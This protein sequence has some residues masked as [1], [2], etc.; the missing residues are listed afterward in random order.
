MANQSLTYRFKTANIVL[1]LIVIN[2][3]IFIGTG[4]AAVLTGTKAISLEKWFVLPHD[5]LDF[6]GQP[7]SLMTYSFLHNDIWHIGI[8]M[9]MLYWFGGFVLNL[10]SEKRFLAI[11]LL[12]AIAGGT[13]FLFINYVFPLT[14]PRPVVGA[15]GA[16][17]AI[18]VFMAAYAPH[19]EVRILRWNLK[20]WHIVAFFVVWDLVKFPTSGNAGG[21]LVHFGGALFGY[22]YARQL[23]KGKDIGSWFESFM[24][25]VANI[26][27]TRKA[28]PFKKVH[29][30]KTTQSQSQRSKEKVGKSDHQ[31]RIDTILDKIGK[32]GYESLS[33]AE[34]DFLFKAGK[35]D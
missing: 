33:K 16:V 25:G 23:L 32:S 10:F 24:D 30:N 19:T 34:K 9:L 18:M 11:Y 3:I 28:K 6:L 1:K 29:R 26:F 27:K 2:A 4:I 14:A 12:G 20:L 35:N 8:N 13:F 15:S 7:W 5:L 22:F 31:K 17:M 21:L